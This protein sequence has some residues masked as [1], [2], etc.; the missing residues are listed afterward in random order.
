MRRTDKRLFQDIAY[1]EGLLA[2][3]LVEQGGEEL[4][5]T[6]EQF[7]RICRDLKER[8][9][10]RLERRLLN[11]IGS[12]DL[13]T[14]RKIVSAFDISFN[15]LNIAEEN[16]AMQQRRDL[17][18]R[19]GMIPGSLAEYFLSLSRSGG[20]A[21]ALVD[22]FP[23]MT[24]VPVMT[25]HPTE[26]KRQTIL[27]K[28]RK[29]YLLMLRR[30]NPLWT[31]REVERIGEELLSE[32]T[33]LWQ[34]G[35]IHLERPTVLEEVENGLFYFK[36]T[37][38]WILPEIYSELRYRILG[39]ISHLDSP[40]P[41]LL[42]FGS[43]IGGDRDG[44]PS[45]TAET[46]V[47]TIQ[48]QKKLILDLY[49]ENLDELIGSLSQSR[50]ISDFTQEFLDSLHED[51]RSAPEV[52]RHAEKRNPHEPYRQKLTFIKAR[53]AESGREIDRRLGVETAGPQEPGPAAPPYRAVSE[54]I[55]DLEVVRR[56]LTQ[57]QAARPAELELDALL[58]RARVFGFHL[59]CLDV[60]QEAR[61]HM[62]ALVEIFST[63][64]IYPAFARAGEEERVKILT[65]ELSL[66][67]PLLPR[68]ARLSPESEEV[69]NTFLVIR[70]IQEAL[71]PESIRSYIIS[72]ASRASDVLTVQLLAKEAGL[73]PAEGSSTLDLVPLFESV[74]ALSA[75]PSVMRSL[76]LNDAYRRHLATRGMRQEIML[77]YS[78]S[79]KDAGIL[80]SSWELYKAQK[81]LSRE[82]QE[83]G[84]SLL[85]FHGR[86]GA[87]GRGGG[88]THR[89]ILAQPK[90]TVQGRI[91]ITEQGEVVSSK[92]ANQGTALH[93]LE[94]LVAGVLKATYPHAAEKKPGQDRQEARYEEALGD[95]ARISHRLYREF[96]T[97]PD[98]HR[99]FQLATPI[100]EIG[101]LKI[102][103][104]PASR[105]GA[106][107]ES[108]EALRAIPWTFSWTQSR[109]LFGGWFPLG[110]AFARFVQ[111]DPKNRD[112]LRE[113]YRRMPFFENLVD[114]I[115]MSLAK[116][117]MHIAQ[118]YAELVPDRALR[119]KVFGRIRM[120]YDLTVKM[121]RLITG[122]ARP[123]DND[124]PLQRSIRLRNPFIDPINYI[125]V[126]L[127]KK[128]RASGGHKR[129]R[130][131]L[132][133][134]VALTINCIAAG[135]RN[136]G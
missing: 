54:F 83:Q 133:D 124:P 115:Q 38:Y 37:F 86:G 66:A 110:S 96:I 97:D 117:D 134:A 71:G 61:R 131:R 130:D 118:H 2:K 45:V 72:M 92:Y 88:P 13:K 36:E 82:A 135:M 19:G 94:L 98:V 35:D 136:T 107:G 42:S 44:N 102:S 76:Y 77:G 108:F 126:N 30:E 20:S 93:H 27:E 84:V 106:D 21:A 120:E 40:L 113:M 47:R 11:L 10:P 28:Y 129:E 68:G 123:L 128:L 24:I 43:W 99:Y 41:P 29:I 80:A 6:V 127:L 100:S 62:Q 75:A 17:Q 26:A 50:H 91:K 53:L 112:L 60:R 57:N 5:G 7:R 79:S 89:A 52:A 109:H 119:E 64:E 33:K 8:Y 104:R 9:S 14:A 78:D 3:V 56:S 58:V 25:A 125:Q 90:D 22:L 69:V 105:P 122:V 15:L 67:R 16:F 1:L 55:L 81:I 4:L 87:V 85:L 59:A 111:K 95:L 114:T 39:L 18:Q 70:R 12:L 132:G 65:G 121:F 116:A 32:L 46:T 103:S 48:R 34:T 31:P 51:I 49:Q 73:C 101:T 63:L 74:E 23:Q